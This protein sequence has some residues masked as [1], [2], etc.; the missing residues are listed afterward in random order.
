MP[1]ADPSAHADSSA[2]ADQLLVVSNR[3]P[4]SFRFDDTGGLQAVP[5]GGGLVSSIGPLL[6]G[7]GTTWASVT[8]G[9]AD[10]AAVTQGRM[11]HEDFT[12][13]PVVVDDDTYRAGCDVIANTTL[14]YVHHHLFDLPRRPRFDRYWRQAW[15][16]Y[17]RYNKLV[18]D[19]VCAHAAPD[20]VVLVQDYHFSLLGQM[21][22][23][24]RPDLRA[25]H[26]NHIPFAD[27]NMLRVL[28]EAAA[29]ELLAGLA[30]FHACG[31]H[32]HRWEAAF[33]ACYADPEL[34]AL[35]GTA[36]PPATFVSSL[37]S[38]HDGL[39]AE[40]ASDDCARSVEALRAETGG[41]RIVL[42]VDRVEPSKNIVRGMLA[43]E[44]LLVAY[45]E[46]IDKVVHVALVYPSR[47]GLADYLALGAEV[48][49]VAERIN[50]AWGTSTWTPILLHVEDDRPRSL[51]AL[52]IS[53]VL[54][55]NP[56]RDGLNLVAKEGAL[57]NAGDGVLVLSHEAGAW[58]E[59]SEAALGINPFDVAGTA[60][61]LHLAL[62][63]DLGERRSRA[64]P[65]AGT[66]ARSHRFRLARRATGRCGTLQPLTGQPFAEA[67]SASYS[68]SASAPAGPSTTTSAL[69]AT[70]GALSS[71]TTAT[72]IAGTPCA[73][74][75]AAAAKAGR[76]PRSSPK[77][78]TARCPGASERNTVPLSTSSGGRSSSD[79]RPGW[80]LKPRSSS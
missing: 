7:T 69:A 59:L 14:W 13:L 28:P 23:E 25:V 76:S 50:H 19:T 2:H 66:G 70:S 11:T 20:S 44:E 16:G 21:L 46:W 31:F 37:S 33:R 24:A 73:A 53:D 57:L 48:T 47:Q 4:L 62:S 26:F 22:A 75:S 42:R 77:T 3:G 39:L 56:V 35:A 64:G 17:R 6:A 18:S 15:D 38:D 52:T 29:G 78:A 63:M 30:G 1:P 27:P 67:A 72:R 55:V 9:A 36:V 71:S 68:S 74:N 41:R 12:L 40:A 45:P 60:D 58:E 10:R 65:S 5:G 61:T 43:F 34:S 54:L 49:H 32:S 80:T 51:A 8:M 79:K